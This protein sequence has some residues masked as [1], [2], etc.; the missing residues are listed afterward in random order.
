MSDDDK[1]PML[2]VHTQYQAY[3]L[4]LWQE[5]PHTPWRASLQNATTGERHGFADLQ[6][7]FAFLQIRT[8]LAGRLG[9]EGK[10]TSKT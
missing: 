7:L 8:S 6:R 9:D 4:R 5:S 10:T 1:Q 2:A 3:L